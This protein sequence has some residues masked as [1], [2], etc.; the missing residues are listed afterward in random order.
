[1]KGLLFMAWEMLFFLGLFYFGGDPVKSLA[2][3][4]LLLSLG[5]LTVACNSRAFTEPVSPIAAPTPTP[6]TSWMNL[7][8]VTVPSPTPTP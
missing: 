2:V 5:A 4:A 7:A 6:E 8:T 1:M 3:L